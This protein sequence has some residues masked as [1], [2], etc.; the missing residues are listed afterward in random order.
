MITR[1]SRLLLIVV[2]LTSLTTISCKKDKFDEPPHITKDPA[3][4]NATIAQVRAL[5]SSGNPITITDE[6]IIGGVVTADDR[7]GN[8]YKQFVMQDSTGAIPVLINKSGLYTDYPIG[9]KVYVKC[10]GMVIGQYGKNLQIGGFVDFT[11]AQPSVGNLPSALA[12][13]YIVKGPMVTPLTPRKISSFAELNLTTN[14]SI[15]IQFDPVHFKSGSDGLPYADIV[16][17][18]SFNRTI[19]D[20]DGNE[21][22]IRTSNFSSF[23]NQNTPAASEKLSIIGIYSIFNTTKQFAIRETS[24]VVTT[25]TQCPA[26]LLSE[27]FTDGIPSN[28]Q[29]FKEAGNKNWYNATAGT[30][31]LVACSAYNSGESSN[32]AWLITSPINLT[33]YDTK[34]LSFSTIIG[35]PAGSTSLSVLISTNYSG[36]GD[37][38]ASGV[39]WTSLPYN[40]PTLPTSGNFGAPTPSEINISSY[41]G[42]VYIAFKYAGS[43][44]G[45]NTSTYEVD[46][47]KVADQ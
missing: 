16:N 5:F 26:V 17:G 33:G 18:Q 23:A 9:R 24:E 41:T 46:D 38:N 37:P 45:G 36:S 32:I 47:V 30:N 39:T 21:L 8:F 6:L 44:T 1:F 42:T 11:G 35:H 19:V 15:L 4:A 12:D 34:K 3:I 7:S 40:T 29:N 43:G 20:C 2:A 13:K 22:A 25:T 10:K 27:N 14:Q 31:K 28:W